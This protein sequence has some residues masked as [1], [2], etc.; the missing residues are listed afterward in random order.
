MTP[1]NTRIDG[2]VGLHAT[3]LTD[4]R[5]ALVR[6]FDSNLARTLGIGT[7][8][9]QIL[10]S[11]TAQRNTLR[12]LHVQLPPHPEAKLVTCQQ[13]QMFWVV[14]DVRG[15]SPTFGQWDA[16]TL[17]GDTDDAFYAAPGLAH[18]CL[19]LSDDVVLTIAS[20][21]DFRPEFGAGIHWQDPEISITWPLDGA[22]ML[23]DVHAAYPSFAAF[24]RML[25]TPEVREA[26]NA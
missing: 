4:A 11:H 9:K 6:L 16:L 1:V 22:P 18:G 12:G 8:W 5:G 23:S 25:F 21:E 19:S 13:G 10:H 17:S 14:V 20:S 15:G 7:T 2:F 3:R 24:R 26:A